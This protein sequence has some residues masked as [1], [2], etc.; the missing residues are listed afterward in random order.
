MRHS[1]KWPALAGDPARAGMLHALM[2]GR[3]LT[4]TELA[5]VAGITPQTASGHLARLTVGRPDRGRKAGPPPLS[6]AGVARGRAHA[7]KHHAGRRRR[8]NRSEGRPLSARAMRRLRAGPHLLRS[9]RRPSRRRACRRDGDA[10]PDRMGQPMPASSPSSGIA[11]FDGSASTSTAQRQTQSPHAVP[12]L[13]RLERTPPASG[14]RGRRGACARIVSATAGSSAS[15]ARAP[16]TITAKGQRKF[17]EDLFGN[18]CRPERPR[19]RY[20]TFSFG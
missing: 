10:R 16:S 13:P 2:D 6:P 19:P 17:R 20:S 15:T 7:G 4:A 1:R 3:A 11:M 18:R 8:R 14:R 5:R 9:S 12:P